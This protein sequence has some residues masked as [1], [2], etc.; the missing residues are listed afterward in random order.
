MSTGDGLDSQSFFNI[1]IGNKNASS[2]KILLAQANNDKNFGQMSKKMIREDKWK[3][4]TNKDLVLLEL[5]D[6]ATD[7][8]EQTTESTKEINKTGQK[9]CIKALKASLNQEEVRSLM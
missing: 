8:L 6:L 3:L 1:L 4:I 7:S 9:E 5:Y 2:R